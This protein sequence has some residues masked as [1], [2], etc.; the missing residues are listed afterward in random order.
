MKRGLSY[1]KSGDHKHRILPLQVASPMTI[2]PLGKEDTQMSSVWTETQ[3]FHF[4]KS[5]A[6]LSYF[7][8][9]KGLI[10]FNKNYNI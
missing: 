4:F 8:T 10:F 7:S 9:R 2:L 6:C 5:F 3:V 1:L